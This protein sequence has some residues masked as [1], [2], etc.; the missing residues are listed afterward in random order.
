[1]ALVQLILNA[2]LGVSMNQ[3]PKIV[4]TG[5][6][7]HFQKVFFFLREQQDENVIQEFLWEALLSGCPGLE[8]LPLSSHAPK[9]FTDPKFNTDKVPK[10]STTKSLV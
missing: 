5:N 8:C 7:A 6:F 9:T 2:S 4:N 10:R 1:M 3:S